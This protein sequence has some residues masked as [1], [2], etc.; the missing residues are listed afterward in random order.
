MSETA[1][2]SPAPA[3]PREP[4][5]PS[6]AEAT[7]DYAAERVP[8]TGR[9]S[10]WAITFV[11]MG[12][13]V[14]ATDLLYGIALGLYFPFWTGLFIALGA[15]VLIAGF[16]ILTGL[17]GQREGITTALAMKLT[18][19]REGTRLPALVIALLSAGF[20][21][22]STGIT[23][24]VLP[25]ADDL[26]L[27]YCVV[28]SIMYTALSIVGF[29]KGL[30]WVGRIS[31]PLMIVM[32]LIAT[33]AAV[34]HAGGWAGIVE[35]EPA[36]AGALTVMAM[37][38]LG[39]NKWMTGATVSPDITRF[40]KGPKAV[41]TTTLAEFIV[42]NFG[43]NLLGIVIGLGVGVADLGTAFTI[44]GVGAL[45]TVAI[46]VQGFP[47]EVNNAYAA[48]LAGRTA[49]GLPRIHVNILIGVIA[50]ALAYYGLSQG[51][52]SSFLSYLGYLGYAI[53]LVPG[54]L[55]ADYFIVRRGRYRLQL[56]EVGAVNW[57]AMIAFF[58][59]LAIN[60]FLGLVVGDSLWH[61]LPL[62]GMLLSLIVSPR[63]VRAAWAAPRG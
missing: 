19:G 35:A 50:A 30:T 56:D 49:L 62:T 63:E 18:F 10:T 28:L 58:G 48:S 32:V 38:G 33:V 25:A 34:S 47:H 1:R 44:I 36:Q 16:A 61:V 26:G 17:I 24:A 55:I 3:P 60:L 11:R 37:L 15:S 39:V 31:V 23:A 27:L 29:D 53:P 57:R 40:A 14:S 45:A 7:E 59:G 8:E 13:T 21:G 6:L 51:I 46:F 9:R 22:Y 41:Y 5:G 12:F 54:I 42:G 2:N 20:V 52:L 4:T 43:F